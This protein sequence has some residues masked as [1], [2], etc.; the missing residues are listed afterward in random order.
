M[1]L[2]NRPA[3]IDSRPAITNQGF[4]HL[5]RSAIAVLRW[6]SDNRIDFV[7]VGAVARAVRGDRSAHGPVDIVPAPYGR[8]LDRLARALSAVGV[9]PRS[10]AFAAADGSDRLTAEQLVGPERHVLRCGE[11]EIDVEGRPEGVSRYQEL[12]YEAART[13]LAD[14]LS[15]EIAAPEDIEHYDQLLRTGSAPELRV[16]RVADGVPES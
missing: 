14:G 12:L 15:I 16:A 10:G 6:L 1:L 3:G 4:E 8:N 7:L 5:D 11:H 2:R 9:R 13:T